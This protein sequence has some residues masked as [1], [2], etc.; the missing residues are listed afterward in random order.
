MNTNPYKDP[1]SSLAPPPTRRSSMKSRILWFALGFVASW[2][3]WS[4]VNYMAYSPRDYSQTFFPEEFR[5]D[6][7]EWTKDAKGRKVGQFTII[8]ASHPKNASA[9]VYPTQPK[10]GNPGVGYEDADSDGRVDSLL[11]SDAKQRTI[12][13]VVADGSFQSYNY[14]PDAIA[15]DSVTFYDGDMDGRFDER[16]GPGRR[17]AMMVDSQ[18]HDIVPEAGGKGYVVINGKRVPVDYVNDMWRIVE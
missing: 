1:E 12:Q 10:W 17:M 5:D 11:V 14:S 9:W 13:F 3:T 8:A 16:F 15:T 2:I 7:P 18:W 6:A 4:V